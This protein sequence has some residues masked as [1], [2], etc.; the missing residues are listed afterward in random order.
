[1]KQLKRDNKD[2]IPKMA[3]MLIDSTDAKIL[4][5]TYIFIS[6]VLACFVYNERL[7]TRDLSEKM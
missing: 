6:T 2:R 3:D 4:K 1:M 5:I 7:Q